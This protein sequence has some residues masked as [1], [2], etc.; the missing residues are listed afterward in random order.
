M[1]ASARASGSRDKS[2]YDNHLFFADSLSPLSSSYFC[3][4]SWVNTDIHYIECS[5]PMC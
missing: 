3:M 2:V 5:I 4:F 1:A